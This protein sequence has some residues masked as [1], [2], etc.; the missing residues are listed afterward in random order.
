[1]TD[2][3]KRRIC[4]VWDECAKDLHQIRKAMKQFLCRL[5]AADAKE[6]ASIKTVFGQTLMNKSIY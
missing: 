5:E 3:L 1:M 2:E 6:G 4:D